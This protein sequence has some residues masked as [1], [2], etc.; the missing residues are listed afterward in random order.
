MMAESEPKHISPAELSD[1]TP[2]FVVASARTGL[3]IVE[4]VDSGEIGVCKAY[5]QL[6]RIFNGIIA[7]M[8]GEAGI[9]SP[10]IPC[11]QCYPDFEACY[12]ATGNY[13]ACLAAYEEC[14]EDCD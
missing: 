7:Q 11:S 4:K 6:T 14:L 10:Q 9:A 3:S 8:T 12:A 2:D 13:S 5:S 1:V